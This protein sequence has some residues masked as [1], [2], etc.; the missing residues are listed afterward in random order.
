MKNWYL[1]IAITSAFCVLNETAHAASGQLLCTIKRVEQSSSDRVENDIL[2]LYRKSFIGKQ[3][4]VDKATGV[5]SGKLTNT[6]INAPQV[7]DSGSASNPYKVINILYRHQGAGKGSMI[8]VFVV[9]EFSKSAEKPFT[10]YDGYR[11]HFGTC[12]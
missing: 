8:Y 7:I 6:S 11:V 4:T 9:D 2:L 10:F 12:R 5:M 1:A 3:F